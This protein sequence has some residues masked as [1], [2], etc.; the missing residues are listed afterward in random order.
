M[1]A[2]I[3][4]KINRVIIGLLFLLATSCSYIHTNLIKEGVLHLEIAPSS[5]KIS[6]VRAY[7]QGDV[8]HVSGEVSQ[9]NCDA[10]PV[11]GHLDIALF[12]PEKILLHT[13]SI[14]Y[15]AKK[16][17]LKIHGSHHHSKHFN[18]N[19]KTEIPIVPPRGASIKI[20]FHNI[21]FEGATQT[22]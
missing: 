18:R 1:R 12:S 9:Q 3:H 2:L 5:V 11:N 10:E 16:T 8:I 20:A 14:N 17:P 6:S 15:G 19:F 22:D 21:P 7:Q 13:I 4:I